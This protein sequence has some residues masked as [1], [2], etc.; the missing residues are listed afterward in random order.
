MD[1]L[2]SRKQVLDICHCFPIGTYRNEPVYDGSLS[3]AMDRI[4]DLPAIIPEPQWIPVTERLPDITKTIKARRNVYRKSERVLCAC[5]Q[6]DGKRLVKE[7]YMEFFNDY[8]EPNWIIP[9]TIHSVTHWM[10]MPEPP[11]EIDYE[12]ERTCRVTGEI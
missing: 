4:S 2:I 1:D 7:G 11:K 8:P 5:L 9:G 12:T 6:A 3:A 10:P